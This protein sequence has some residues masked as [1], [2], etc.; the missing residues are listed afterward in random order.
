MPDI[1]FVDPEGVSD[2]KPA[3]SRQ[4]YAMACLMFGEV[5]SRRQV[6]RMIVDLQ[7]LR[8]LQ[9]VDGDDQ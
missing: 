2:E 4:L 9:Q 5:P 3:T 8:L 6:S 1:R 7:A